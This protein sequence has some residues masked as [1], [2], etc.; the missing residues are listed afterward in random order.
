MI[1]ILNIWKN[2]KVLRFLFV[3]SST[4]LIDFIVYSILYLI[5]INSKI[6]KSLGFVSGTLYAYYMN[7]NITFKSD[8]KGI[9]VFISFI[10]LYI[11]SLFINVSINE[12]LLHLTFFFNYKYLFSFFIATL[13]SAI[14]NYTVMNLII[15]KNKL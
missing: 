15:F 12:T 2:S 9:K 14:L 10:I 4:V 11:F 1:K 5:G 13:V 8:K 7:K 6:S 3:G